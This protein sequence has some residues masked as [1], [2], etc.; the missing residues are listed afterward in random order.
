MLA[1]VLCPCTVQGDGG[2][3]GTDDTNYG[4][5]YIVGTVY[6]AGHFGPHTLV[7]IVGN[8]LTQLTE[9]L[10]GNG[11]RF[12]IAGAVHNDIQIVNA[13]VDQ[14][15]ATCN[16]LGGE[17]AADTGNGTMCT[18]AYINAIQL[19]QLAAVDDVFNAVNAVVETVNNTDVQDTA[20]LM[21]NLLHF[22]SLCI[23]T[24]SGLLTQNVFTCAHSV[25]GNLHMHM[26]WGTYGNSLNLRV[27]QSY[28]IVLDGGTAAV[29]FNS[30]V[31]ALGNNVTKILDLSFFIFHVSRN[32]SRVS[33]GTAT[34]NGY[35]NLVHGFNLL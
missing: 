35:F 1:N 23:G 17:S 8:V 32:V 13:P 30:S 6:V 14:N 26:V 4:I 27:V 21:L 5:I 19:T 34:D 29:L 7:Y 2:A 28:M 25:A 15:A 18:E 10:A 33:N 9:S 24:G 12:G 22:Q 31:S 16:S 3:F 11:Q 20:G